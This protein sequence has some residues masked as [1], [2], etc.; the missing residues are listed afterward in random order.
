M[1]IMQVIMGTTLM[2][3]IA[4]SKFKAKALRLVADVADLQH[5]IV[6]TK[7][8]KPV[9]CLV[10]YVEEKGSSIPGNLAETLLFEKD[11]ITPLDSNEWEA[12]L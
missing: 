5:T 3:T 9:A 11:L 10:P 7:R 6:I 8:G 2:T 12:N 4:I 1:T